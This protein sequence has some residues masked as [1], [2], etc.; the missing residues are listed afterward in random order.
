[1]KHIIEKEG[2]IDV[3]VNNAGLIAPGTCIYTMLVVISNVFS[4][5]YNRAFGGTNHGQHQ[6]DI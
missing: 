4:L 2:K 1:V 5:F 3:V 6:A